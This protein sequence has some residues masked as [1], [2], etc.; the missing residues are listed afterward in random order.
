MQDIVRISPVLLD[1]VDQ[2]PD[3]APAELALM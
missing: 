3:E 2:V 1:L